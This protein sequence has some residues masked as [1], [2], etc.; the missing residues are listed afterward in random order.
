MQN[1]RAAD[2][3]IRLPYSI[4]KIQLNSKSKK[5]TFSKDQK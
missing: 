4:I 5:T 1:F 2:I 3:M